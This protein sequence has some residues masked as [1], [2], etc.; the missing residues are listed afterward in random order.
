MSFL[1]R[2][3]IHLAAFF[4]VSLAI[5]GCQADMPAAVAPIEPTD[6]GVVAE[7]PEGVTHYLR[8]D[9]GTEVSYGYLDGMT[10]HQLDGEPWADETSETG[11]THTL[12]EVRLLAPVA[13]PQKIFAAALNFSTHITGPGPEQPE[14]FLKQPTSIVGPDDPIIQPRE[15][16]NLHFEAEPVV[17][18]GRTARNISR[19][20]VDDYIF[21]LTIGNDVSE[22]NWQSGD[23]QW[24]RGKS[25]DTFGPIGPVIAHGIDYSDLYIAGHLNGELMQSTQTGTDIIHDIPAVVSFLSHHITLF[26]GDLIFMGTSEQTQPMAAGDVFEAELEGVGILR[27]PIRAEAEFTPEEIIE[28]VTPR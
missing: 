1:P 21:G 28:L 7:P 12:G 23:V 10:I 4:A 18:I 3:V 8:Y 25:L 11:Q 19:E 24:M 20:E 2:Y 17:V 15:S 6:P 9:T 22:R 16:T 5:A 14:L 26:P 13:R 27:N